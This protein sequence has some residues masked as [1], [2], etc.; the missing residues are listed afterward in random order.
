MN[1]LLE[2]SPNGLERIKEITIKRKTR[3]SITARKG[4]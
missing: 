2:R 1:E 4:V 3:K